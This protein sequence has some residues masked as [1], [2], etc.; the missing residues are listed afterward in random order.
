MISYR[1]TRLMLSSAAF[2]SLAGSA[3]ALDGADLLKKINAA[4]NVQGGTLAAANIDVSGTTVTLKGTTFMP[5]GGTSAIALGDVTLTG[6]EEQAGGGYHVE[7]V[8][9]PDVNV[10]NEGVTITAQELTLKG[11]TVPAN[12]SGDSLDSLLMYE[13]GHA[14]PV[15]IVKDGEEVFSIG[16][17]QV[18][19]TPRDNKSGFDFDGGF[20]D[21]KADLTKADDPQSKETI[22]KLALQ[23]LDG[24]LTMKGGWELG[25]GTMDLSE[26]AF[27]FNNVGRL[28]VAFNLSGYTL[29]FLRSMQD[30]VKASEANPN[31]EQAQ[32]ALG[33]AVLGLTQ[34]LNFISAQIRFEDASITN[35]VLDYAGSQQGM[36]GKQFA[37]SLKAMTPIMLAQLNIP[38]LQKAISAAVNTY[39]DDPKSFTISAAPEKP[40]PFPM[41][42]GAAMGA[43]NTLPQVLGVKV[44]ANN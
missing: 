11:M 39:L 28:N 22:E 36:S 21:V 8:A 31:K 15:R 17:S 6:V 32:Q 40:V 3:F 37:D 44:T 4:Y 41:I 16:E 9:F 20:R 27:D 5:N 10:T 2:L 30:A 23:H 18:T 25:S 19:I 33:L 1:T 12:A 24:E 43:P 29:Q 34:Q 42:M 7:Q 26:F 13:S 35:R 14:G 38:E